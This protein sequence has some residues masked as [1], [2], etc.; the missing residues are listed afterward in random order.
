M[1]AG[2]RC[3]D[4]TPRH[5]GS[6]TVQSHLNSPELGR[7]LRRIA[8]GVCR[9]TGRPELFEDALQEAW[10]ACAESVPHYQE[11]HGVPLTAYLRTRVYWSVLHYCRANSGAFSI[12]ERMWRR[13]HEE[14][15]D[16]SAAIFTKSLD[17]P[18]SEAGEDGVG[19]SL[20]HVSADETI[21]GVYRAGRGGEETV[22]KHLEHLHLHHLIKRLEPNEQHVVGRYGEGLECAAIAREMGVSRQ[23]VHQV[24]H[25]AFSKLRT[26]WEAPSAA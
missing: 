12:P 14:G 3:L 10:L 5:L 20:A 6:S 11:E 26:W 21:G 16:L 13:R 9:R 17:E 15:D 22:W 23:R 7:R 2:N 4:G 1:D 24:L 25:R 18:A 8:R 19:P